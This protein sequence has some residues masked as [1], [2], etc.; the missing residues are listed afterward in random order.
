MWPIKIVVVYNMATIT[1]NRT[2]YNIIMAIVPFALSKLAV[3]SLE[4][5]LQPFDIEKVAI[6]RNF[7][8]TLTNI[9]FQYIVFWMKAYI[10]QSLSSTF[11]LLIL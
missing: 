7:F 2:V 9:L 8:L 3:H 11:N 4:R 6:K 1:Y 5:Q 10:Q